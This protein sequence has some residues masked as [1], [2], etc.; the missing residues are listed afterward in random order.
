MTESVSLCAGVSPSLV[1]ENNH[2]HQ[3]TCDILLHSL[4][5][6]LL[7]DSESHSNNNN[8]VIQLQTVLDG[9]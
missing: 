6:R 9:T 4:V 1:T 8:E 2:H 7:K 3:L 5:E